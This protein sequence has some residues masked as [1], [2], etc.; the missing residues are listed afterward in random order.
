MRQGTT[1]RHTFTLPFD[2]GNVSKVRVIYAQRDNVRIVKTENDVE[3]AENTISVRLSQNDTFRLNHN[4]KTDIQI[5]VLTTDGD[6]L[7]SDVF[8]VSTHQCLSEEVL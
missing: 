4:L 5:R 1:P 6:A 3:M 8:T 2:T 7:V